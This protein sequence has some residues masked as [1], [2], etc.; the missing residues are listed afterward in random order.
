VP[1]AEAEIIALLHSGIVY[2]LWTTW[3]KKEP[4]GAFLDLYM[5]Q[6]VRKIRERF[7]DKCLD[8]FKTIYGPREAEFMKQFPTIGTDAGAMSLAGMWVRRIQGTYDTEMEQNGV[9]AGTDAALSSALFHK[10]SSGII[11]NAKLFRTVETLFR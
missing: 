8:R 2:A 10:V 9:H 4:I 11:A 6:L 7:G 5:P 1:F 3:G